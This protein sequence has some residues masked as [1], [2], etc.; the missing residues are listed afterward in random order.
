MVASTAKHPVKN[1]VDWDEMRNALH[2]A[3]HDNED[4]VDSKIVTF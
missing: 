2:S 1:Y 4:H 3:N